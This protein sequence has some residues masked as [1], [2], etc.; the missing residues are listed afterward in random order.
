MF[1]LH[2]QVE[3]QSAVGERVGQK[4]VFQKIRVL[5]I[6]GRRD[7]LIGL[8]VLKE[9]R[10]LWINKHWLLTKYIL[11][12][13]NYKILNLTMFFVFF[14]LTDRKARHILICSL[15][16]LQHYFDPLIVVRAELYEK[17]ILKVSQT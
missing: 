3:G 4:A 14:Y 7:S 1:G 12:T 5:N 2:K 10:C 9:A 8:Q 17:G 6:R 13:I 15:Y 16:D 11:K